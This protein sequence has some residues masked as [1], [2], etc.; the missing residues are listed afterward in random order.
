MSAQQKAP[1]HLSSNINNVS[2]KLNIL[3]KPTARARLQMGDNRKS[4]VIQS[5][6]SMK[7]GSFF[8][9]SGQTKEITSFG[10]KGSQ[11]SEDANLPMF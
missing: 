3:D 9:T 5:N 6:L 8:N 2:I 1:W 4:L 7:D 11:E 10:R